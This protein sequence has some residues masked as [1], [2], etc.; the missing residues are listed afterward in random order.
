MFFNN[1]LEEV[2]KQVNF[3]SF[4]NY[5]SDYFN[6][7]NVANATMHYSNSYFSFSDH[8]FLVIVDCSDQPWN[9]TLGDDQT[10][11]YYD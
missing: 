3:C 1:T 2:K 8:L 5:G 4:L 7:P 10:I 6:Q 9:Q 11:N